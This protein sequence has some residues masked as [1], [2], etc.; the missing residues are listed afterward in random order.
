MLSEHNSFYFDCNGAR[1][2]QV[3]GEAIFSVP[4]EFFLMDASSQHKE[5]TLSVGWEFITMKQYVS[6]AHVSDPSA[7]I[8]Q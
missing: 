2:V 8:K 6:H 4:M 3:L 5:E 7:N 1:L